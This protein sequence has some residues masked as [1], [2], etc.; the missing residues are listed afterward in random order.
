[1]A[2]MEA[3]MERQQIFYY[4][5]GYLN[6]WTILNVVLLIVLLHCLIVYPCLIYW[7]QTQVLAG[8]FAVSFAAW[9]YKHLL[10]HRMALVTD[11]S[12]TID[13]CRA[14]YWKDV[15]SAEERLVRCC[16]L[17]RR[18]VVLIPKE[19][20]DYKY[21]FLQKHNGEFTPFSVPLYGILS[22]EDEEKIV[23]VIAEKTFLKGLS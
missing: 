16:F 20:I 19:G 8:L 4:K 13:H 18:I 15:V 22:K 10:K 6:L 5:F 9:C 2:V 21:N 12:I 14:L 11:E 3:I 23:E 1:M 17:P 7:W